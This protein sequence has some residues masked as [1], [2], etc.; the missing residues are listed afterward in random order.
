MTAD[1]PYRKEERGAALIVVLL[2]IATLS[3]ILLSITNV[4]TAAVRRSAADRARTD[5][6]W[7]AAAGELI[8]Q[9]ILEK[10]LATS[11]T[12]MASGEGIFAKPVEVP[13]E[14][15]KASIG[16]RDAT[17][18]FNINSL[19][20]GGPGTYIENPL[21]IEGFTAMLE[22]L[23]LGSGEA[24][25]LADVIVDF[26]DSDSSAHGQGSE[27]GFYSALPTPYRTSGQ[28]IKSMSELRA[29]DSVSR[30]VYQRIRPYLCA[31]DMTSNATVNVNMARPDRSGTSLDPTPV[32][33]AYFP[34]GAGMT[35]S[36]LSS[37][38]QAIPPGG[39]PSKAAIDPELATAP[40]FD[41]ISEHIEAVIKLEVNDLTIEEKLLFETKVGAPP[42]LLARSFGDDY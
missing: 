31:L 41:V 21:A 15:G 10:Y 12:K 16:F 9:E 34:T 30:S 38:L 27:D 24:N 18:C 14:G 7:R 5:F 42:K 20:A 28:L 2:L 11:P 35:A 17:L 13:I 6:Y 36:K 32:L 19:V 8:A 23:G 39:F 25:K 1:A 29:M 26:I 37:L 3:F 4:V 40:G 33:L 22:A